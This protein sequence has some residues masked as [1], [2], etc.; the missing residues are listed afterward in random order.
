MSDMKMFLH[1]RVAFRKRRDLINALK[2][3]LKD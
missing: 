2:L 1:L 3:V